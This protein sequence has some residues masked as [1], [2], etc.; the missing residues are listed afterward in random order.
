MVVNVEDSC[1]WIIEKA[2]IVHNGE[3]HEIKPIPY[4]P[5]T[6]IVENIRGGYGNCALPNYRRN[7]QIMEALNGEEK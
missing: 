5:G 4:A 6:T 3:E 2:W 1:E 7:L